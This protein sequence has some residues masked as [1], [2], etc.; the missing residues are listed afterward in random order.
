M[1]FRSRRVRIK[2]VK[3]RVSQIRN[4]LF[5]F[6][7]YA[8]LGALLLSTMDPQFHSFAGS[9]IIVSVHLALIHGIRRYNLRI[10][11]FSQ[12]GILFLLCVQILVLLFFPILLT[13]DLASGN[14]KNRWY[15]VFIPSETENFNGTLNIVNPGPPVMRDKFWLKDKHTGEII[16]P[17]LNNIRMENN[18]LYHYW[19]GVIIG[20]AYQFAF[21]YNT[22]LILLEYSMVKLLQRYIHILI[23]EAHRPFILENNKRGQNSPA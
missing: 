6:A 20:F 4:C 19:L 21:L 13:S 1:P 12:A 17:L 7:T 2:D 9:A 23:I 10:L 22:A 16:I 18:T 14:Y 5:F 3:R 15:P 11:E 8:I